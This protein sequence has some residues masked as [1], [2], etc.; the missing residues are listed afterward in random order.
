MTNFDLS[1]YDLKAL[2]SLFYI[3]RNKLI[4]HLETKTEQLK[5]FKVE[6]C[7]TISGRILTDLKM[8]GGTEWKQLLGIVA[9]IAARRKVAEMTA[10]T[11]VQK[12]LEEELGG[13]DSPLQGGGLQNLKS[14]QRL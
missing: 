6:D 9:R 8:L 13:D 4:A 7:C 10:L 12:E 1:D 14:K 3:V 5:E 2:S 11:E